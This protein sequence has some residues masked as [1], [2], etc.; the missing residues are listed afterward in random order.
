MQ[1]TTYRRVAAAGAS[2]WLLKILVTTV[3]DVSGDG[4]SLVL[5]LGYARSL[6]AAALVAAVLLL[7]KLRGARWRPWLY[8]LLV[9]AT[10]TLGTEL[11]DALSHAWGWGNANTTLVLVAGLVAMLIGWHGSRGMPHVDALLTRRDE[12]FYWG[13]AVLANALGSVLGDVLG[14]RLGWGPAASTGL[15]AAVLA[16][17][18]LLRRTTRADSRW[19]YWAAWTCSRIPL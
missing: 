13:A 9:L 19:L 11:S 2:F 3:G 15:F 5:H 8:W 4:M 14:D 1:P 17:L 6:A 18:W 10:S 16:L 7:A 12:A